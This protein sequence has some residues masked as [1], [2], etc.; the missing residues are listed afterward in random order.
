MPHNLCNMRFGFF[1]RSKHESTAPTSADSVA[2]YWLCVATRRAS[3]HTRSI[4]ASCGLY[5]GKNSN[6]VTRRYFFRNGASR[7]A[8]WYRAL[9]KTI[10]IRLPRGRHR[11][12]FIRKN[13]KVSALN[14]SQVN[15]TNLPVFTFIG[16][17]FFA[18][19]YPFAAMSNSV[20]ETA[21]TL[22]GEPYRFTFLRPPGDF[23]GTN[24]AEQDKEA[25]ELQQP[26][27]DS[28]AE[29]ETKPPES[30]NTQ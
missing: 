19:T 9:S 3:F 11:N 5:G 20:H 4:G 27:K 29:K 16:S 10:T 28:E 17:A 12:T 14:L 1:H 13:L 6:L 26:V 18:V 23:S 22:V 21:D 7:I 25:D 24:M 15:R 30:E 2:K 8:W